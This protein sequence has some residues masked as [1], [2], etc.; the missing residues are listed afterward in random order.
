MKDLLKKLI[1]AE[2]TLDNGELAAANVLA[3]YLS[4]H[5]INCRIDKWEGSRAN[6]IAHVKS[7]GERPS[8]LF[9]AHLDVVPAGDTQWKLPPFEA[10]EVD[11][12]IH[13]RGAA[14][15]KGPIASLAAAIVDVIGSGTKLKGDLIL[16]A[17]AGEET[18]SRGTK[19]FIEKD[20]TGLP[21]LAGVVISEPTD[22]TVVTAHRGMLWL[23]VTTIGKSAHGSIPHLGVNAIE[24]MNVLLNRLNDYEPTYTTHPLLGKCSMSINEIHGGK[25]TNV[26]PDRCSIKIDIRTLPGQNNQDIISDLE[27]VCRELQERDERF[28][29]EIAP[30]VRFVPALE[31]DVDSTFVKSFCEVVGMTKTNAVG[32]A[33]DGPFFAELGA[34]VVMFGPG[35]GEVC[36]KPDEYIDIADLEKGAKLYKNIILKFLCENWV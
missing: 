1:R 6:F 7:N 12:R 10:V 2:A 15:M 14:D 34:P 22:F 24:L 23:E 5:G 27:A 33:T 11:G 28:E 31:T 17:T 13:G 9:A 35:K 20:S 21:R 29:A 19:R 18:D 8:L 30:A 26:V 32:F 36:H 3:E 25:V 4:G 16:A